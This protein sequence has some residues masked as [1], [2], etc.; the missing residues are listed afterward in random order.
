MITCTMM[1]I[2]YK[3]FYIDVVCSIENISCTTKSCYFL[4]FLT[5]NKWKQMALSL[6]IRQPY[7]GVI[8]PYLVKIIVMVTQYLYF[9]NG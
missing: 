4:L 1:H 6:N 2:E 8:M 7:T 5:Y 3:V 9:G